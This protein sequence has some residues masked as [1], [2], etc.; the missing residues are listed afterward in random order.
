M[1][2]VLNSSHVQQNFGATMDRATLGDDVVIERYGTPRVA[3]ITYQRLLEAE[4][5]PRPQSSLRPRPIERHTGTLL[6]CP[7]FAADGRSFKA[8][9]TTTII[10]H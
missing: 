3:M 7:G 8:C 2:I 10:T 6:A 9:S 4:R 5:R 1:T